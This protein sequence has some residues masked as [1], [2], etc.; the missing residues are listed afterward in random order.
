MP[1]NQTLLSVG[2]VANRLG[3]STRTVYDYIETGLLEAMR[4]PT[5]TIRIRER[6]LETFL[7]PVRAKK[8]TKGQRKH[9]E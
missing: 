5:G 2:E 4:L 6:D 9:D 8:S 7:T 1:E 3:L